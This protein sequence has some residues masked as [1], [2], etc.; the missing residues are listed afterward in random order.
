MFLSVFWLVAGL[1]LIL[2]GADWLTGGASAVARRLGINDLVIGLTIVAFGTSTP[3]L[4]ISV[5]SAIHGNA[6][7]AIG[8]NVG[9]N[10]FN[11]LVII[12][13]V[14]LISPIKVQKSVLN[15]EIPIVV[16]SSVVMLT[17]GCAPMLDG[18]PERVL[19][20]VDGILLLIFFLLFMRYTFA[21]ARRTTDTDPAATTAENRQ[22]YGWGKACLLIA[23]GFAA[24]IFGGDRFVD[25]AAS[26][27]RAIGISNAVIGLTIVAAGT[28]LP[29]LATSIVA[30][31]KGENGMAIG[32]V[33]GSCVFNIFF[34]LG[35]SATIS[36]LPFGGITTVDLLVMLGASLLFWIT[37]WFFRERTITRSEGALMLLCY[38]VYTAWLI[39]NI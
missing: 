1:V 4:V 18:T 21:T 8:N 38:I 15:N 37:G 7:L 33:I 14:A 39:I 26:L 16:L 28:S 3:E 11:I 9:S 5:I 29:E 35:T 23:G 10:I 25:G 2:L 19:T 36:P 13:A 6:P 24:L 12:G 31:R 17:M 27:A 30:A 22:N 32:N 20:R 34:I